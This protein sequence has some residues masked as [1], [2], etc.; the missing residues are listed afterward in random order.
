MLSPQ[1]LGLG[2]DLRIGEQIA[3]M[4]AGDRS[5]IAEFMQQY[6]SL[7]RRRYRHKLGRAMR[8]LFDSQELLSTITR[9]LDVYVRSGRMAAVGEAQLWA[10]IS[11]IAENSL[12]DKVRVFARL[13]TVEREDGPFAQ[14]LERRMSD[15]SGSDSDGPELEIDRILRELPSPDDRQ[16]AS[17]WMAGNTHAVIAEEFG[18]TE[19]AA[20]VRWHRIRAHLRQALQSED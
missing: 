20:R 2:H 19:G 14:E 10:L 1:A 15:R 6:G 7:I 9:R 5:A 18:M 16:I 17:M 12:A 13:Q 4:R 8:R 3:R 11:R